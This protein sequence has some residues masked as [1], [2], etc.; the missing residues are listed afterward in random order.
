MKNNRNP[1]IHKHHEIPEIAPTPSMTTTGSPLIFL[2][3]AKRT[4]PPPAT[5]PPV[6][7]D[8]K[9]PYPIKTSDMKF[10][11]VVMISI[12][13]LSGIGAKDLASSAFLIS[14]AMRISEIASVSASSTTRPGRTR[15]S[16]RSVPT[17]A[18]IMSIARPARSVSMRIWISLFSMAMPIRPMKATIN[19]PYRTG[20]Y[21]DWKKAGTNWGTISTTISAPSLPGA[22]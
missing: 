12:S 4:I 9:I 2:D 17:A 14:R 16:A 20:T 1:M 11:A 3:N 7:P 21:M 10:G 19:P 13:M 15:A 6:K 8:R 5:A 22:F 18:T